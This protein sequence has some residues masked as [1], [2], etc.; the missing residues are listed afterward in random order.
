MALDKAIEA[1]D[2]LKNKEHEGVIST[3][4]TIRDRLVCV[5]CGMAVEV[6]YPLAESSLEEVE[7]KSG[8]L[9]QSH[10]IILYGYCQDCACNLN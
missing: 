7:K 4:K 10:R 2:D 3:E 9:S 1:K 8:F 6:D 5:S